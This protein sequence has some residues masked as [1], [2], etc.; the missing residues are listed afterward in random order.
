MRRSKSDPAK[1]AR[2]Y[3][4]I[5]QRRM[6]QY[7]NVDEDREIERLK[8]ILRDSERQLQ[9]QKKIEEPES[10]TESSVN[11]KKKKK[12]TETRSGWERRGSI[13]QR[14]HLIP[15]TFGRSFRDRVLH[16]R[17]EPIGDIAQQEKEE[18]GQESTSCC[19]ADTGRDP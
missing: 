17:P 2:N 1:Y 15:G 16:G 19:S 5:S 9:Q 6:T 14:S 11:D 4:K 7:D 12:K 10:L 3:R 18:K 8:S 13:E